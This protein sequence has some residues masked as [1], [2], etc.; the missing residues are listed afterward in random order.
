MNGNRGAK[1]S[2]KDR[3]IS[4]LYR[5]RYNLAKEKQYTV[6]EKRKQ[7]RYLEDLKRFKETENVDILEN[8]DKEYLQEV[9]LFGTFAINEK[10]VIVRGKNPVGSKITEVGI[11]ER[12]VRVGTNNVGI[13]KVTKTAKQEIVDVSEDAV[14]FGIDDI[15]L[16]KIEM[17]SPYLEAPINLKREQKKVKDEEIILDEVNKFIKAAKKQIFDI[18]KEIEYLKEESKIDNKDN[19]E[20]EKRYQELRKKIE[21]LKKKFDAIKYKYDLSEF[22]IL[23]SLKLAASIDDYK[24]KAKLNETEMLINVCKKEID[25]IAQVE[26]VYVETKKVGENIEE[27]KDTQSNIKVKF[28]KDKK[29]L[30][31]LEKLEADLNYEIKVQ[32]MLVDEMYDK[33][34]EIQE[35]NKKLR[36]RQTGG[37]LGSMLRIAGGILTLPLS[38]LNLFGISIGAT[39]INKGLKGL[40]KSFEEEEKIEIV[41][42]YEDLKEKLINVKDR[43]EYINLVLEDS[44]NEIDKFKNNINLKYA[45]YKDV[46]PEYDGVLKNVLKLEERLIRQQLK[47]ADIDKKV[48]KEKELNSEKILKVN[49]M[50]KGQ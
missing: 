25:K 1:G 44:L 17:S 6:D 5:F 33:A 23:E 30:D 4:M 49:R 7:N 45:R 22:K 16:K 2:I 19:T 24:D 20:L 3:L 43:L 18:S 36:F 12:T 13:S 10:Q 35:F 48:E 29:A 21:N 9:K 42:H 31:T 32:K 26:I 39:L 41:Y 46:I 11:P 50:R 14:S 15:E 38:G 27:V 28:K 40:N 37:I 8:K 34:S 47:I